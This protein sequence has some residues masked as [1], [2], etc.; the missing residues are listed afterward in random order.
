MLW[1]FAAGMPADALLG[2]GGI[3]LPH[4]LESGAATL[5]K[6]RPQRAIWR[7]VLPTVDFYLKH[8]RGTV[9]SWMQNVVRAGTA[10]AEF[11]RGR[12][13]ARRGVPT[14]EPLAFGQSISRQRCGYLLTRTIPDAAPLDVFLESSLAKWRTGRTAR[15]RQRVAAALGRFLGDL[16]NAGVTHQDLH[17]GNLLVRVDAENEPHF[18]LIDLHAVRLGKPLGRSAGFDNLVILNRWFMLRSQRTDRLRSWRAYEQ[19]RREAAFAQGCRPVR[20]SPAQRIERATLRSNLGFWRNRDR[21][22]LGSNRYFRR[23]GRDGV[24]GYAV[25]DLPAAALEPFLSDPDSLFL[26]AGVRLLKDSP[27]STVVELDLSTRG[28]SLSVVYK[29][30]AVTSWADPLAALA[31]PT[32]ALRSWI[33]GHGLLT[34]LLPTPRPLAVLHRYSNGLPREGYLLTEKVMNALD[35]AAYVDRLATVPTERSRALLRELVDRV[36]R[37]LATLHHRHL[38][39]RDLKAPNLLLR[40][41]SDGLTVHEVFFI[42]LVGVRSHAK[43]RRLRRIQNLAR[44]HAS[45]RRHAGITRTDKLRFLRTYLAWGL[46]GRLGWKRWWHQVEAATELKVRRN[47]RTGRPLR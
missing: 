28:G 18:W 38:S 31:R 26:R 1:H 7:V 25:A 19:V 4:W 12:E 8:D 46:R 41:G 20:P 9:R 16:H 36:G 10:C 3:R 5:V 32:G 11:E 37:L 33:M 40:V 17:P 45:F 35:L 42:D 21:R 22:C 14:P 24:S 34:R 6:E 13:L 47:H 23:V 43:L 2:D 30:F 39:H 44:L 15:L 29:R 27:S